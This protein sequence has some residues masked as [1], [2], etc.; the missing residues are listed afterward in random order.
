MRDGDREVGVDGG[1][2][3]IDGEEL[4]LV[5]DAAPGEHLVAAA[6]VALGTDA[7]ELVQRGLELELSAHETAGVPAR[8]RIALEHLDPEAVA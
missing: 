8:V 3:L 5:G 4:D 1:V 6:A 2:E 7:G